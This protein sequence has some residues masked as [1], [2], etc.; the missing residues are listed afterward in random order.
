MFN[1]I[2]GFADLRAG[3]PAAA[4]TAAHTVSPGTARNDPEAGQAALTRAQWRFFQ[5]QIRPYEDEAL[6]FVMNRQ[7]PNEVANDVGKRAG[8]FFDAPIAQGGADRMLSRAGVR[9]T[10]EQRAA[11]ERGRDLSRATSVVTSKNSAR[12]EVRDIQSALSTDIGNI[13]QGYAASASDSLSAAGGM[14]AARSQAGQQAKA[15]HRQSMISSTATGAGLG[16]LAAS[17]PVG[18]AIGGGLGLALS[19][20]G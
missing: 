14:A 19:L 1:N 17:G 15:A 4:A 3:L 5:N 10:D 12:R 7:R 8:R 2:Q 13:G 20:L 18:A 6:S 9:Q 11:G 16:W